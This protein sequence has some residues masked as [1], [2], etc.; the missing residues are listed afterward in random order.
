MNVEEMYQQ[1][2]L[3][4]YREKHHSGLR[5]DYD[6][7]VTQVNPSCGDELLLRVHLD[8][9]VI[10]DVSYDAVGCSISQAST[11][12]MTDLIIGKTIDEAQELYRGFQEMMRSRG[13]IE[14]D[15]DTY[16]DAIAFEGVAKL[17]ARVKCA[18][19]GWSALEDSLLK[20]TEKAPA[21]ADAIA[22]K[23]ETKEEG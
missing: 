5:E 10:S 9:D 8:G 13:T 7:E 17:M 2:I 6:A 21:T 3:D 4:H 18:M 23:N 1:I 19:L 11:S 20:A 14:L 22:E 16:E 12:V 15:E